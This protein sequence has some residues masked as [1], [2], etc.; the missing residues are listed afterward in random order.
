MCSVLVV[1]PRSKVTDGND[2][3]KTNYAQC[4]FKILFIELRIFILWGKKIGFVHIASL[5][6]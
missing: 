3:K 4:T 2:F 6:L 1:K 5:M